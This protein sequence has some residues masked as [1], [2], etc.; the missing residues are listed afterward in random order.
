M[1]FFYQLIL[2][3]VITAGLV[4][5]S[6]DTKTADTST[7]ERKPQPFESKPQLNPASSDAPQLADSDIAAGKEVYES[8]CTT[9]HQL[10]GQG[11]PPA[12]PPLAGS[13]YMNA[14][15]ERAMS[16]VVHGL[17]GKITVNGKEYN[18]IMPPAPRTDR[19]IAQTRTYVFN[20]W[21]NSGGVITEADVASSRAAGPKK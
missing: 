7:E 15:K 11:I 10:N 18:N 5:C 9:C 14:D 19:E 13:D 8:Y 21:G 6:N 20:S 12:F 1:K 4:T 2:A 3:V 16:N 17:A